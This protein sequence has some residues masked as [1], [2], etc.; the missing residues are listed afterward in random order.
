MKPQ[1]LQENEDFFEN[2]EVMTIEDLKFIIGGDPG[3]PPPPPPRTL[4]IQNTDKNL[5]NDVQEHRN[6][7]PARPQRL[8]SGMPPVHSPA[9]W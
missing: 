2:V 6:I 7:S 4:M 3:D 5:Y 8:R 9:L 1:S